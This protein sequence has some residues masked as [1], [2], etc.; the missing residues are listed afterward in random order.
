MPRKHLDGIIGPVFQSAKE[1]DWA[2]VREEWEESTGRRLRFSFWQGFLFWLILVG[3]FVYLQAGFFS[4][5][6]SRPY[7]EKKVQEAKLATKGIDLEHV[8][9]GEV[10]KAEASFVGLKEALVEKGQ[11]FVFLAY[12]PLFQDK[13]VDLSRMLLVF[14][15]AESLKE[16]VLGDQLSLEKPQRLRW[17]LKFALWNLK[18]M[19]VLLNLVHAEEIVPY[20][21]K[22]SSAIAKAREGLSFLD[23]HFSAFVW[24]LG[25]EQERRYLFVFPNNKEA[26]NWGGFSGTYGELKLSSKNYS[27]FVK[28][29]YYLDY[30]LR[31]HGELTKPASASYVPPSLYP[32]Q[33]IFSEDEWDWYVLRNAPTSLDF[34]TNARRAIWLYENVHQQGQVDG[35]IALTPNLVIDVLRIVGPIEMPEY[36]VKVGADNFREIIE[37]KVEVDNPFKKGDRTKDPKQI[38]GDL[39]PRFLE[40]VQKADLKIKLEIVQAC[41][42]NLNKK[43]ILLY[44][45]DRNAQGLVEDFEWGGRLKNYPYD[46]LAVYATNLNG[47]KSSLDVKRNIALYSTIHSSGLVENRLEIVFSH[48]GQWKVLG[49]SF[50]EGDV[51]DLVEIALPKGVMLKRVL[52]GDKEFTDEVGE[53]KEKDKTVYFFKFHFNPGEKMHF[54]FEYTLPNI[55]SNEWGLVFQKQPGTETTK[56]LYEVK[57]DKPVKEWGQGIG[58]WQDLDSDKEFPLRFY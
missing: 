13:A 40:K 51:E 25:S 33:T 10:L 35:L 58:D 47:R 15:K 53:S 44:F 41:L 23:R 45:K 18:E 19:E 9:L 21:E 30:L 32:D 49:D 7:L 22:I 48:E 17:Q 54:V 1:V 50:I 4:L 43:Q 24:L 31:G 14:D 26:R 12:N 28:D 55:A 3:V 8:S 38:L 27:L 29:I 52:R 56:F 42:N 11:F 2:E 16:L 57:T 34:Q 36:G 20:K 5:Y 6:F 46:Y 39:A 37:Y